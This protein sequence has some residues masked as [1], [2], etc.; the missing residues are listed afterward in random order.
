[1]LVVTV[2]CKVSYG[3]AR[4]GN[5]G[6]TDGEAMERLWSYLRPF[7]PITK[8]MTESHRVDLLTDALLHYADRKKMNMG[9]LN[10][11]SFVFSQLLILTIP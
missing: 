11:I 5:L 7:S 10:D 6:L 8:E 9:M 1:M 2:S 4:V 3:S